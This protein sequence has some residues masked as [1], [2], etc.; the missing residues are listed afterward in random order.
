MRDHDEK[1]KGHATVRAAIVPSQGLATSAAKS[2]GARARE[3]SL[4]ADARKTA[5]D[6]DPDPDFREGRRKAATHWLVLDR[7]AADKIGPLTRWAVRTVEADSSL[8]D[9]SLAEQVDH[10]RT[11]LPADLIGQH[12][13]FH[14]AW[15]LPVAVGGLAYATSRPR[16]TLPA[17][18]AHDRL[19]AS[20]SLRGLRIRV[21]RVRS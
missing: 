16:R 14:I 4:L 3:R 5:A 10:F 17:E 12:A 15:A 8:R 1:N 21:G 2:T 19:A 13:V 11:L 20:L 18:D 9:A 7:R 6:V